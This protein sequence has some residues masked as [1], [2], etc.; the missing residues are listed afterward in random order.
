MEVKKDKYQKICQDCQAHIADII[1][2]IDGDWGAGLMGFCRAL[3]HFIDGKVSNNH[4]FLQL[5]ADLLKDYKVAIRVLAKSHPYEYSFK[6]HIPIDD[7]LPYI[8][9]GISPKVVEWPIKCKN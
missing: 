1:S 5:R 3:I 6:H 8:L 2:G 4:V 9:C 7:T